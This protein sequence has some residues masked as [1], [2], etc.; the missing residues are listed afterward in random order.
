MSTE[1]ATVSAVNA[2]LMERL[3]FIVATSQ[4]LL[5]LFSTAPN[6]DA[7]DAVDVQRL[8]FRLEWYACDRAATRSLAPKAG[9]EGASLR[10]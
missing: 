10:L 7:T 2:V 5:R 9:G 3:A 4:W 8:P 1:T 6:V